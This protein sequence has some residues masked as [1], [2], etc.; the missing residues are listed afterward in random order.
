MSTYFDEGFLTRENCCLN[1]NLTQTCL[2]FDDQK[3][4]IAW[5]GL[6]TALYLKRP[7]PC[8][9]FIPRT[10]NLSATLYGLF[11][12]DSRA[13]YADFCKTLEFV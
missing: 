13:F 12:T 9:R 2:I 3:E 7:P 10:V 11:N 8:L 1:F 6:C 5:S 4:S